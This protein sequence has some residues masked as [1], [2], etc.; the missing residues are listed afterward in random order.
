MR[1]LIYKDLQIMKNN[2]GVLL[3][4]FG[5]AGLLLVLT[6]SDVSFIVSYFTFFSIMMALNTL[7]YDDLNHGMQSILS[8]PV[9]RSGYVKE[10]YVFTIAFAAFGWLFAFVAGAVYESVRGEAVGLSYL[11]TSVMG[12]LV[13]CGLAVLMIPVQLYF[14]A[15][16]A[17][18][19]IFAVVMGIV[20]VGYGINYVLK[21]FDIELVKMAD[22]L[23]ELHTAAALAV[24]AALMAILLLISMSIS[25]MIVK[26]KE[27]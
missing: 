11:F 8:L 7:G 4:G 10:K 17:R 9:T 5:M 12:A 21:S 18:V 23:M 19:A 15:E 1:G 13:M 2:A 24:G 6:D 14:G 20:L 25:I 16:K 3:A 26:K 27:Y 22:R